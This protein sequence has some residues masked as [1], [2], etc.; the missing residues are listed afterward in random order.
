MEG[1]M[2]HALANITIIVIFLKE[3]DFSLAWMSLKG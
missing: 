1:V 3:S 2:T